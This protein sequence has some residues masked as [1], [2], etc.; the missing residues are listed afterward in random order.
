M[1]AQKAG[2]GGGGILAHRGLLALKTATYG[3]T[4]RRAV[5]LSPPLRALSGRWRPQSGTWACRICG[6]RCA[7]A[8]TLFL[9]PVAPLPLSSAYSVTSPPAATS[10]LLAL[11]RAGMGAQTRRHRG[12]AVKNC[13]CLTFFFTFSGLSDTGGRYGAYWLLSA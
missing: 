9:P 10:R 12:G 13:G 11:R 8:T 3:V 7:G 4:W 2:S 5:R 6:V 1:V